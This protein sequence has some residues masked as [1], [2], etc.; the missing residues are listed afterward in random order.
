M[1]KLQSSLSE[2]LP[3]HPCSPEALDPNGNLV[4]GAGSPSCSSAEESR[5]SKDFLSETDAAFRPSKSVDKVSQR[6][7]PSIQS[8]VCSV[9]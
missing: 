5:E 1:K 2:P 9:M 8:G 7:N 3:L 4:P 6:K